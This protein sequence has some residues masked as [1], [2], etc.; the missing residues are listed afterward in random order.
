MRLRVTVIRFDINVT[1]FILFRRERVD[2]K[3]K[4]CSKV[5][6]AQLFEIEVKK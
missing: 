6:V 3:V 4:H 1:V 2:I 5:I